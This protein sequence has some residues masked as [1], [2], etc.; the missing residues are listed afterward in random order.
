LTAA[1]RI[2]PEWTDYDN[3][4]KRVMEEWHLQQQNGS[5]R[6]TKT[7]GSSSGTTPSSGDVHED[8]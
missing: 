8:L 2:V 7:P 4:I 3:E 6:L 5:D 1:K